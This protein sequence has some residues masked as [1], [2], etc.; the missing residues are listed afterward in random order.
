MYNDRITPFVLQTHYYKIE[1]VSLGVLH[2][3]VV[4]H[5]EQKPGEG[6]YLDKIVIQVGLLVLCRNDLLHR[7]IVLCWCITITLWAVADNG[8]RE[9][10][11]ISF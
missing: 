3:V 4:G 8:A 9:T 6:W 7:I 5:D 1:A 11:E 10:F 2:R